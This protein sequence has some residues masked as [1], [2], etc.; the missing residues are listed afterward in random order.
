MS[1]QNWLVKDFLPEHYT[2][3]KYTITQTQGPQYILLCMN[4]KVVHAEVC[5][6]EGTARRKLC[7]CVWGGGGVIKLD[8]I[9]EKGNL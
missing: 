3:H 6:Q 4:I 7:V 1:W 8:R 2:G 5:N 9:G